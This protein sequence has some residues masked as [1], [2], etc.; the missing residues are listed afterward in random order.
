MKKITTILTAIS[1][2]I[3]MASCDHN[4]PEEVTYSGENIHGFKLNDEKW[5]RKSTGFGPSNCIYE[6]EKELI[7]VNLYSKKENTD[8]S[9]EVIMRFIIHKD[10]NYF[11]APLRFT[12]FGINDS[13]E[14]NLIHYENMDTT[15]CYIQF[16]YEKRQYEQITYSKVISGNLQLLR[17]DTLLVGTFEAQL[18]NG[19]DTI[20][21]NDGKFDYQLTTY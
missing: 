17:F 18:T 14:S 2:L 13:I 4:Y 12:F 1:M 16:I 11:E 20:T 21:L 6:Q 5:V 7:G 9:S 8:D 3:C 10:I 15:K 19:T